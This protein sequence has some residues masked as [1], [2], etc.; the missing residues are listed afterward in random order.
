LLAGH[1]RLFLAPDG[2]LT[3]VP[4]AALPGPGGR[5]LID[6]YHLSYVT[7]GRDL[8]RHG[9]ARPCDPRPPLVVADPDFDLAASPSPAVGDPAAFDG[10]SRDLERSGLA[11]RPLPGTRREGEKIAELLQVEPLMGDR[12]LEST[13]KGHPSPGILHIA[14]HGFF[15]PSLEVDREREGERE[16]AWAQAEGSSRGFLGAGAENPLL[17]SGLA[18]A[19][20]NV[21]LRRGALPAEAEDGILNGEDVLGLDLLDNEL[22]VLSACETALGDV[23]VGDG[24]HGLCRAFAIAGARTLVMSLWKVPDLHTRELMEDFYR[25][26]LDGRPRADALREAQS[27]MKARAPALLNWGAFICQGDPGPLQGN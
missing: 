2:D 18:L 19:G 1:T 3:R 25:R 20:A 11:F 8:L 17:R 13:I 16:A 4:F 14:T 23:L 7:T 21:R 26:V 5:Y 10:Q 15:L 27:A 22:T 12:A 24:V 6:D 9:A